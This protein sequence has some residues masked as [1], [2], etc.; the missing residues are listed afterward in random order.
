AKRVG[1]LDRRRFQGLKAV[2]FV[3]LADH[4]QHALGVAHPLG[5]RIAQASRQPGRRTS[6]FVRFG[7]TLG[8]LLKFGALI[9]DRLW[10]GKDRHNTGAAISSAR[11][12]RVW[13]C[14]ALA[15]TETLRQ[16]PDARAERTAAWDPAGGRA[17]I[18]ARSR[19]IGRS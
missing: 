11:P 18:A 16:G 13:L 8:M 6:L 9:A 17:D 12:W 4:R 14:R 10:A 7:H 1:I 3:D 19:A 5:W 2:G 15:H